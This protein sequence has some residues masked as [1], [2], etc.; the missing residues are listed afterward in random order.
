MQLCSE[1]GVPVCAVRLAP[2]VYGRGGGRVQRFMQMAAGNGEVIYVDDGATH[3]STV[4]VGDAARLFLLATKDAK[5]GDIFN[6]TSSTDVTA[7]QLAEAMGEALDLPVRSRTFAEMAAKTGKFLPSFLR[8]ENRA[9]SATSIRELGWQPREQGILEDIRKGSHQVVAEELRKSASGASRSRP[10]ILWL[11][12]VVHG[13]SR[14]LY[15]QETMPPMPIL[16][17]RISSANSGIG[18]NDDCPS[19]P[20][21]GFKAQYSSKSSSFSSLSSQS[22]TIHHVPLGLPISHKSE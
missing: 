1:K 13:D 9:S 12:Q 11:P 8:A 17:G 14:S 19:P 18:P 5:S 6:A 21:C 7:R 20:D 10:V 22:S 15:L 3:T 4:H 16:L 2:Y